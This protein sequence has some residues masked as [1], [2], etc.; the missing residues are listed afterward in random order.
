MFVEAKGLGLDFRH[1]EDE[2]IDFN[3]ERLIP[4]KFSNLG[5]SIATGD[6]NGDLWIRTQ[7][8]GDFGQFDLPN[9]VTEAVLDIKPNPD[10]WTEAFVATANHVFRV[11]I[12]DPLD[13]VPDDVTI[14]EVT[15][16]LTNDPTNAN[17]VA[18]GRS[19]WR[20]A[21]GSSWNTDGSPETKA[22]TTAII[23]V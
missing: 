9:G 2:F 19:A 23:G 4:H 5:P 21:L 3:R 11:R 17:A 18:N 20:M 7:S 14:T 1:K 12:N 10:D 22:I 6:V 13:P 15:R 16:N 8:A